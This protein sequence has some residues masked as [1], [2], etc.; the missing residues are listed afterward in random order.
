MK[1]GINSKPKENDSKIKGKFI[2]IDGTDGSGKGTQT[3]LLVE[4]LKK[5]GYQ[6]EMADFPQYGQKSAGLVEEYLNGKY[7]SQVDAYVASVMYAVD[8][9]DA[10]FKIRQWLNEG[11]V[12]VSNRYVTA[13]AGHQGGKIDDNTDRIKYFKWLDNLEYNVFKIPKPDLNLIL[14]VPAG[15]AQ[16]LVDKKPKEDRAYAEGKKRDIHEA[17]LNHLKRAEKVF[18]QIVELFPNTKLVECFE[19]GILLTPEQVH[20]KIWN[21]VRRLVLT[22]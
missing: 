10:S 14:H 8:R 6:V 5:E 18:L 22:K 17:D 13:N 20:N 15:V 7:G 16:K 9:F 21:L 12:V 1:F 11:K 19:A 4:A 2:V 3:K